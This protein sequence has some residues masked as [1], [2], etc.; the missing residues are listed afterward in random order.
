M[1][2]AGL[3]HFLRGYLDTS[4]RQLFGL[5]FSSSF[6]SFPNECKLHEGKELCSPLHS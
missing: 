5:S 2:S 6:L 3:G 1:K 4:C